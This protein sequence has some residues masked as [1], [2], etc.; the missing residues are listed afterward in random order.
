[1]CVCPFVNTL[2]AEP[3]DVRSEGEHDA[4]GAVNAQAF[5]LKIVTA[6]IIWAG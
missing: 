3:F 6:S 5:S 4:G 1:M 2:T